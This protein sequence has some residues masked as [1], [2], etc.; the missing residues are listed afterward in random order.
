LHARLALAV[1][2]SVWLAPLSDLKANAW[3]Q[4]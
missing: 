3:K 4:V 1:E 2:V